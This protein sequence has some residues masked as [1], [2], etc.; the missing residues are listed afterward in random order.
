MNKKFYYLLITITALFF[1]LTSCSYTE[2][3]VSTST[4]VLGDD[5]SSIYNM[6]KRYFILV[7]TDTALFYGFRQCTTTVN[8]VITEIVDDSAYLRTITLSDTIITIND[9]PHFSYPQLYQESNKFATI[10]DNYVCRYFQKV[11][12]GTLQLACV[13][14]NDI[15][16]F[17]SKKRLVMPQV[18]D[19]GFFGWFDTD[20]TDIPSSNTWA[21]SPIVNTPISIRKAENLLFTGFS[22]AQGVLALPKSGT[23]YKINGIEYSN[24]ILVKTYHTLSGEMQEKGKL[25]RVSGNIVIHRSYFT[26]MGMVDQ[27][28][29]T[30]LQKNYE[31][32]SIE[33]MREIIY[34][35]RGPEGAPIYSENDFP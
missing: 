3:S 5:S 33:I 15:S 14:G 4:M 20:T 24:G 19:V 6:T 2:N 32:G 10:N 35:A 27:M 22:I 9:T 13:M 30:L 31:D 17:E 29:K 26:D 8:G 11:D 28:K 18:L 21:V 7:P 23:S 12:T 34:V 25:V 16:Y 1:I